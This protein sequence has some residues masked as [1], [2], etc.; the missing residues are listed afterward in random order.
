ME[1]E[2]KFTIRQFPENLEQYDCRI[3]EQGYLCT[4]PVVRIR[5]DNDDYYL[6]YKG[7]GLMA[8]EEYNLPLTKEGYEHMLSKADGNIIRKKR[9]M[10]PLVFPSYKE[11]YTPDPQKRSEPHHRT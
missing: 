7:R 2:R 9:Y 5:R 1:I 4:A 10:I 8:R 11:G 6:T 3:I